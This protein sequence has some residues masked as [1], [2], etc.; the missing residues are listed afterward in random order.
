MQIQNAESPTELTNPITIVNINKKY[1]SG[2][3]SKEIYEATKQAWVMK[4]KKRKIMKQH[5]IIAIAPSGLD[6]KNFASFLV[7]LY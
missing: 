3:A 2:K 1:V 7:G 6:T 5:S 4:H